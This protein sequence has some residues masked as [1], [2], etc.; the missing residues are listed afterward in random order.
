MEDILETLAALS[1]HDPLLD[2]TLGSLVSKQVCHIQS[3]H[4]P[5]YLNGQAWFLLRGYS[6]CCARAD[7]LH[8]EM[9]TLLQKEQWGQAV[10]TIQSFLQMDQESK[11]F[12]HAFSS[13][14]LIQAQQQW[15]ASDD[16]LY[17]FCP[18]EDEL[19]DS[20]LQA[21]HMKY[22]DRTDI[23]SSISS[24]RYDHEVDQQYQQYVS[25]LSD[26]MTSLVF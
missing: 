5:T 6:L 19:Y 22:P 8:L 21:A 25:K 4:T 11:R 17:S 3:Q 23:L 16:Y 18:L 15:Q 7:Q 20:L 9:I 1:P 12:E 26:F 10:P 13:H 24:S 14:P 2:L